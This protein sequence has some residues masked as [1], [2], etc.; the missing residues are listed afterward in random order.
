MFGSERAASETLGVVLT[1]AV[2]VL[3]VGAASVALVISGTPEAGPAVDLGASV[4]GENV[5]VVNRGGDALG[6]SAVTVVLRAGGT[7]RRWSPDPANVTG[8]GDDRL[9]TGERFHRR[10]G[11]SLPAG[12]R[13]SVLVVHRPSGSLLLDADLLVGGGPA[14]ATTTTG[15]PDRGPPA[16]RPAG[17]AG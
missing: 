4:A 2:V 6:L 9:E 8:D 7:E 14:T 12:T 3:A 15:A 13:V 5:T 16:T 10:H 17:P 1:V 11:A